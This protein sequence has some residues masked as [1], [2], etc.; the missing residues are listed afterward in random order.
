MA[1]VDETAICRGRIISDTPSTEDEN[2][3]VIW[4]MRGIEEVG[5][6]RIFL[7]I[8]HNRR[9]VTSKALFD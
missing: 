5:A 8:V 6:G 9:A 3:N 7:K 2:A 1:Q 4:L